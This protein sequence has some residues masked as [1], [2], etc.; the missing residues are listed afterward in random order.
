[1]AGCAFALLPVNVRR[2]SEDHVTAFVRKH[3][4]FW[5]FLALSRYHGAANQRDGD[6]RPDPITHRDVIIR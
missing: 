2:V 6:E 3:Q 5:R 4:R 1:V